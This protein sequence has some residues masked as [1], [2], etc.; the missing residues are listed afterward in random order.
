MRKTGRKQKHH[1]AAN[2]K[3]IEGL[4]KMVDG[5]WRIIGSHIRFTEPDEFKA[6]EKFKQ[7]TSKTPT[8][9][10]MWDN[11]AMFTVEG[12]NTIIGR[13][14]N[15]E[16]PEEN[17]WR[18]VAEE[19]SERPKYCAKKT[20]I[21]KLAYLT[22]LKPPAPLPTFEQLT[23]NFKTYKDITNNQR[24]AVINYWQEF[25][26]VTGIETL[27]DIDGLH[28]DLYQKHL[29]QFAHKTRQHRVS[30][31]GRMLRYNQK[32]AV[33][34]I[35][36]ALKY[37]SL[38]ELKK[39]KD[40]IEAEPTPLTIAE[41]RKLLKTASS[42]PFNKAMILCLINFAMYMQ[43]VVRL[44]WS[45]ITDGQLKARRY[46]TGKCLR[47]ALLWPETIEALEALPKK[48]DHIF[49]ADHGGA[50]TVSGAN[51]R[52][53]R[54]RAEAE[55]ERVTGSQFRD[56]ASTAMAEAGIAKDYRNMVKGHRNGMDDEY[57]SRNVHMVTA[58][59]N[60]VREKYLLRKI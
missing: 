31:V 29:Q 13:I 19:I 28:A 48:I 2:G 33:D 6:I 40:M 32:L 15:D 30:N 10:Q 1:V 59:C 12:V 21:E 7:L 37:L 47:V 38:I 24:K 17:F 23:N 49:Q 39:D 56:S 22:D 34:V 16:D 46:K 60:A 54:I 8:P 14:L 11:S 44:K 57:V 50:I 43:E 20:G 51:K 45:E 55:L 4:S 36:E 42:D 53:L 3:T 41:F 25:V 5:R 26:K 27:R 9:K 58:A 18:V 35:D 52:F